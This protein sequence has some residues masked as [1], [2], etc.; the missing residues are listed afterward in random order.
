MSAFIEI[1]K[2]KACLYSTHYSF[3]N[4]GH[5]IAYGKN[6]F[7]SFLRENYPNLFSEYHEKL[8]D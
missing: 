2:K 3:L 7:D 6:F 5:E 8:N 4:D 1:M